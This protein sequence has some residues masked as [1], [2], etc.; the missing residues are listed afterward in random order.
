[1]SIHNVINFNYVASGYYSEENKQ[2]PS[3]SHCENNV[4]GAAHG[5]LSAWRLPLTIPNFKSLASGIGEMLG[6]LGIVA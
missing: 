6:A 2:P 5:I 3:S 1:M 4:I